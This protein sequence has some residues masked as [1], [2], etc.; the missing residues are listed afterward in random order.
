MK[1]DKQYLLSYWTYLKQQQKWLIL[2]CLLI[3]IIAAISIIQPYLLKK[4][5][6]DAIVQNNSSLLTTIALLFGGLVILDFLCKTCQTFLFQFIGQK[7]ILA[8]RYDLFNHVITLST[9][10]YDN[11]PLGVITSRLTSDIE[12]LNESFTSGLVTLL[13]DI[14]TLVGIISVMFMLS[15]KL[16][17]V[18]LLVL[19]PMYFIVNF[20]RKKLRFYYNK[21]RTTIG[22]LNATIQEQLQGVNVIQ[23]YQQTTNS[24]NQFNK[25][26]QTYTHSTLKSVTYDAT[27]YSIIESIYAIMIALMIW[28]G[29]AQYQ[30]DIITIGLLVAFIDYIHKFFMPLKELSTKFAILQHALASLEKIF[31]TLEITDNIPLGTKKPSTLT[32]D[33]CFNNVSFSYKGHEN[34]PILN[35]LSFSIKPHQLVAIVGPTGSGKT[36]ILRLISKLYSGYCGSITFN[37]HELSTINTAYLRQHISVINQENTLFTQTIAFNI[38]LG[39]KNITPKQIETA[40]KQVYI[41]DFIMSLPHQYNTVL[42]KGSQSISA[43]QAQLINFARAIVNPCPIILLDEATANIDSL[44]EQNIQHSLTHL[45]QEKTAIVVAHRLSTIKNADIIL[46]INDG[47]IIEYGSHK[48]LIN[49]KGFYA[50]LF[51]MQFASL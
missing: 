21:I 31:S 6:D 39:N 16:T 44:T 34:K 32:G 42:T 24:F 12:S 38:T 13:T 28:Y 14:L 45:L 41:H 23:M 22:H 19:P 27:L 25:V 26:N 11:T 17:T 8:I 46:A 10:Y 47:T 15:P 7:T 35:N 43:G 4:A 5:I 36:S 48:E 29:W 50:N 3:P 40:A 49:K 2:A 33:I 30:Q 9:R 18:T 51:N 1:K 20:F 37:N